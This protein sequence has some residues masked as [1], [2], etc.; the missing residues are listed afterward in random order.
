[1]ATYFNTQRRRSSIAL[2]RQVSWNTLLAQP[3]IEALPVDLLGKIFRNLS[4][5]DQKNLS[6][7]SKRLHKAASSTL[8]RSITVIV[9]SCAEPKAI[10][11]NAAQT[12]LIYTPLN[13]LLFVLTT[14]QNGKNLE[15]IRDLNFITTKG[16]STYHQSVIFRKFWSQKVGDIAADF[17]L[18]SIAKLSI[19]KGVNFAS[20]TLEDALLFMM[21]YLP[22]LHKL[23]APY[24]NP[25][26]MF[27]LLKTAIK[28]L[29]LTSRTDYDGVISALPYLRLEEL[30]LVFENDS[31]QCIVDLANILTRTDLCSLKKLTFELARTDFN[32]PEELTWLAFFNVLVSQKIKLSNLTSL[33]LRNCTIMDQQDIAVKILSQSIDLSKL[34]HIDLGIME[35]THT[36]L[37]HDMTVL[38]EKNLADNFFFQ[39][40]LPHLRDLNSLAIRPTKNCLTCQIRG[41]ILFL[42][43]WKDK[44]LHLNLEYSS[45]GENDILQINNTIISYQRSLKYLK[46]RDQ[47][48]HFNI[49]NSMEQWFTENQIDVRMNPIYASE[50]SHQLAFPNTVF[51]SYVTK[52]FTDMVTENSAMFCVFFARFF[53]DGAVGQK[54]YLE[55]II[56]QSPQLKT[57]E[58]FGF[59][60]HVNHAKRTVSLRTGN[61]RSQ[62]LMFYT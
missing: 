36:N 47:S 59:I 11:S 21:N 29:T 60:L 17:P 1:M 6:L 42:T 16:L 3:T 26:K 2:E 45:L 39:K 56:R 10:H 43:S 24:C 5:N 15:D 49:R 44:L 55:M 52:D 31:S 57:I 48:Y 12:T 19:F 14:L 7:V 30:T 54:L 38:N 58:L 20:L 35:L 51:T 23:N 28:S 53:N 50:Q 22:S 62:L 41:V 46:Y 18:E 33:V 61:S 37:S 8:V 27:P 32:E 34:Q 40:L 4:T 9:N 25:Q 13:F